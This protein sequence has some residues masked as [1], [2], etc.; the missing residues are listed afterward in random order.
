MSNPG[1]QL[2][3]FLSP[4]QKAIYRLHFQAED[5]ERSVTPTE[6]RAALKPEIKVSDP[7]EPKT[8]RLAKFGQFITAKL[9]GDSHV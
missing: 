9:K 1:N 5:E 8:S 3:D 4:G 6:I 2:P 7:K